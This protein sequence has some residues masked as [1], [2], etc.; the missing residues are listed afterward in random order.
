MKEHNNS[1]QLRISRELELLDSTQ[2]AR[3][4]ER[5]YGRYGKYCWVGSSTL[6]NLSGNDYLGLSER[7]DLRRAFLSLYP[8]YAVPHGSTSS[9]LLL[10]N[11]SL[12]STFEREIAQA[13]KQETALLFNSGYHANTAI[14]PAL[15]SLEGVHILA[16]KLVHASIIDGIRLS[17]ASFERFRHNDF[18]HLE[19]LLSRLE[20][21]KIPI[22]VVESLYSMDGDITNLK[23]LVA[24]KKR[25][26]ELILYVDE[27]HAIG[28]IGSNGY[29]VAEE[30]GVLQ[31]IDILVGTF[32]K[33]LNSMG[34]YVATSTLLKR[35]LINKARPLIFSTML[36]EA[37]IAWS[38]FL[39]NLLPSFTVERAQLRAL[40]SWVHSG[41]ASSE[42]RT[43]GDSYIVPLLLGSNEACYQ[44]ALRMQSAGFEVR[45]IRYPTV[46]KG[47]ARIRLSL[48]A[49]M[50]EKDLLPLIDLLRN[51]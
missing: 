14:L 9:R 23:A 38:R 41:I 10:G 18:N 51:R 4:L 13:L 44:M 1:L 29:G 17:Q 6:L 16:D 34:A 50:T 45:P 21:A 24:L 20:S 33:A 47:E 5:S 30:Q 22:V 46:P 40:S 15:S 25:F 26:P 37:T 36:P 39:F 28:A 32:G 7:E 35:F 19:R 11:Y 43:C 3:S 42:Y 12:A 27:A 48:T 2:S 49:S 8:D 31:E